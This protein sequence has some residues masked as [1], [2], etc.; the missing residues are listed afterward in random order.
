MNKYE[1]LHSFFSQFGLTAYEETT[2]PDN[3]QLPYL[4]YEFSTGEFD[5]QVAGSFSLWYRDSSW[6][7]VISKSE[8]ISN[9]IGRGGV[10]ISYTGG[11][12][13]ITKSEPWVQRMSDSS[14]EFIRRM[15][16]NISIEFIE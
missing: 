2:V 16:H 12:A 6:S 3:A 8:Q 14:D 11:G 4:T 7:N 13:W 10:M 9:F 5:T 15:I 1:A